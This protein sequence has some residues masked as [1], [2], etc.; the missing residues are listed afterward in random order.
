MC[1]PWELNPQPFALLTQCSLSHRNTIIV[2]NTYLLTF[3]LNFS[4]KYSTNPIAPCYGLS[5]K[6]PFLTLNPWAPNEGLTFYPLW[7]TT[8]YSSSC[9]TLSVQ[10]MEQKMKMLENLQDDFD[11]NYK[12][13]KS[14]GG[15]MSI[16]CC[17]FF[18]S[19]IASDKV[20]DKSHQICYDS[21][22]SQDLNGNSQAAA[23][24][25]KMSQLEQM[26]SALDQ[27]RR[28]RY[29]IKSQ[30]TV[31]ALEIDRYIGFPIFEHF[32]I[33]GYWF[34]C[35]IWV[36]KIP[37]SK[38]FIL[39]TQGSKVKLFFCFAANSDRD[40]RTAVCNGLCA[41]ESDRWRTGRLE[42]E[43]ADRLH[44]RTT[45]HLPGPL[46]DMVHSPFTT[47]PALNYTFLWI[48]SFIYFFIAVS[49]DHLFGWVT[50]A[51]KTADQETGGASTEGLLQRRSN[52]ST[53]PSSGGEDR[54]PVPQPYEEVW[55]HSLVCKL[56]NAMK[57]DHW[58]LL[59]SLQCICCWEAAL[60]AHASWP[61]T[62][63]QNR[64]S[65][66]HQSQVGAHRGES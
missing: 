41:E 37:P 28:V 55:N 21:E 60:Y 14:A 12:T 15:M 29:T 27:L 6:A 52:Y 40:G 43:T 20:T 4:L 10:D 45:E 7:G 56:Y 39:I 17:H 42:E 50:V 44:W 32:T 16:C 5:L 46:G 59:V 25:L 26:L 13:L 38:S 2:N 34:C 3:L 30:N 64:S 18:L 31:F 36:L 8:S 62:C 51:D 19:Q 61:T 23:T 49:Q 65:V 33:I 1:D 48:G 53:P 58:C 57:R 35:D 47:K 9:L 63:H 66:H 22:L 24:R 54:R 11:F